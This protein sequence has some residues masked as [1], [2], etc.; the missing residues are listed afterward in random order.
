MKKIKVLVLSVLLILT[1]SVQFVV[2]ATTLPY[3]NYTFS[4]TDSAVIHGPQAYIPSAIIYGNDWAEGALTEPT[5]FDVDADGNIYI[6]DNGNNRVVCLDKNLKLTAVFSCA[7]PDENGNEIVL[8]KAKGITVKEEKFYICDT[9]NKRILIYNKSDG[10][11]IKTVNAPKSSLL[12]E[13]F[14]FQPTKVAVDNKGNLYVVSNGTYE[15]I[16]NMKDSGEF[17]NFFASNSV[18]ASAWEL[19]WRRFSSSKQRK[20]MEQLVPQDFSSIE[21][22]SEGFFL[23]TTY[24]NVESSMV[25]R[26]NQGGVNIIRTL[27]NVNITGD[28]SKVH[29][30]SLAGNSSFCDITSGPDK[31]YACLDKTRGKVYCYNNDGYL[32]YTFGTITS[33]Y[34]GFLSPVAISYLDDYRIA[35]LDSANGALTVF[36]TTDYADA[37]NL[38]IKYQNDLDYESAY[39]QWNKVLGM[40]GNYQIAQN[41]IGRACYNTG[42]YRAAMEYFEACGNHEMYSDAR[43]AI[44]MN[45]IYEYSW[46][47]IVLIALI[48]VWVL[49]KKILKT[50]KKRKNL[51]TIR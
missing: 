3:E 18:T 48:A 12:G 28:Q 11:F 6:L 5:D 9:D 30:G 24:T 49:A 43:E 35:V 19:F 4:E 50:V 38:G 1:C 46:V 22:D 26:V 15:G 17:S 2:S 41:M 31:L 32:L 36:N 23:I 47:A 20:T 7:K 42:D 27:S 29:S 45:Y 21:L 44:R 25:K 8:N 13:D 16:I 10:S 51:Q 40:N 39:K 33:Q 37:V 14:I 34:G